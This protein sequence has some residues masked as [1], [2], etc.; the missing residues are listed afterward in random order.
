M[1][2]Q[3]GRNV[4]LSSTRPLPLPPVYN[5]DHPTQLADPGRGPE[6]IVFFFFF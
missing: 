6:T 4:N 3:S 5:R 1:P 2:Q